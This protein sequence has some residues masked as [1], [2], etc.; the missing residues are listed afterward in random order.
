[1]DLDYQMEETL[2][3][4]S[5]SYDDAIPRHRGGR[6]R[7][8][9]PPPTETPKRYFLDRFPRTPPMAVKQM[10]ACR[11]ETVLEDNGYFFVILEGFARSKLNRCLPVLAKSSAA[12]AAALAPG[13]TVDD[14]LLSAEGDASSSSSSG[15]SSDSEGSSDSDDDSSSSDSGSGGSSSSSSSSSYSSGDDE[16][17]DD[18]EDEEDDDNSSDSTSSS[19]SSSS[20][21]EEEEPKLGPLANARFMSQRT[22]I[23][24]ST[25]E[26]DIDFDNLLRD[27]LRDSATEGTKRTQN[28]T[29]Q[30]LEKMVESRLT[31]AKST[32]RQQQQQLNKD[33][34]GDSAATR[35]LE[36]HQRLMQEQYGSR[37]K[38]P[39]EAPE[40][41]TGGDGA[42]ATPMQSAV[43]VSVLRRAPAAG[44][45]GAQPAAAVARPTV[46]ARSIYIPMDSEFARRSQTLVSEAQRERAIVQ[47]HTRMLQRQ[48]EEEEARSSIPNRFAR[49]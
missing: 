17:D 40:S 38:K 18:D 4:L 33:A 31:V 26:D 25:C 16:E 15:S 19:S 48:H 44:S 20:S 21:E 30:Q 36:S 45:G 24:R 6:D 14:G 43:R 7:R 35:V 41:S 11:D 42:A 8:A 32:S 12:V 2:I 39:S 28:K 34:D 9:R 3:E 22:P 10:E 46:E 13:N 1:M 29:T 37:K 23:Q 27:V 49:R 47:E 5:I